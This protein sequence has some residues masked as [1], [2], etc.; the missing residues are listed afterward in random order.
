MD[1]KGF[2]DLG[3]EIGRRVNDAVNSNDFRQL[4]RDI[5][6]QIESAFGSGE[7]KYG[8]LDGKLYREEFEAE[9]TPK[10]KDANTLAPTGIPVAS[11][12]PGK[13][14]GV[15]LMICGYGLIFV[16]GC[17]ELAL[18]CSMGFLGGLLPGVSG[19]ELAIAGS[20]LVIPFTIAGI[21]LAIVG[22]K[23]FRFASRIR[24]YIEILGNRTFCTIKEL[25]Q[26]IGKSPRFVA[27]DLKKMIEKGYFVEGHLDDQKTN[28]IVT[29]AMY[30]QYLQARD[31]AKMAEEESQRPT[32]NISEEL[33]RVVEEG[34][35][36]IKTIQ[37]ANDAI[38]DP[39][40]S[41]K[42]FR[43]EVIVRKIFE[44][45]EE[46]PDQIGQLRRFMNYYMPTT[47]KLVK[48]YQKLDEESIHGKNRSAAK[49][50]I[51]ETLDTINEA[52]EKLYD[53]MYIDIAMDVSSDISVLKTI[54][55]QEGLM[56]EQLDGGKKNE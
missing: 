15:V 37:D 49:Q 16:F 24:K 12:L 3:N 5:R 2:T 33:Q 55:A 48:A 22:T 43:M 20:G 35:A 30:Q 34:N 40:I 25:A 42:L 26:K 44:Y 28:F 29:D 9:V 45:V 14:P 4:S 52:Y 19:T 1:L 10:R 11:K 53:S 36:Y 32:G 39:V 8:G 51:A 38:Y 56:K 21:V 23:K 41:D 31:G 27:R 7:P 18:V 47:E 50:E 46:H 6:R 17:A 54:F 13:V